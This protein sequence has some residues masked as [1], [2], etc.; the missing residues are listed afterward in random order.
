MI[1]YTVNVTLLYLAMLTK[2]MRK[3]VSSCSPPLFAAKLNL[4]TGFQLRLGLYTV[5]TNT[6]MPCDLFQ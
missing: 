6:R 2:I 1:I 4:E 3:Y 5:D